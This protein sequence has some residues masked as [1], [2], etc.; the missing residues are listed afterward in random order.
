VTRCD[1]AIRQ[2]R[3]EAGIDENLSCRRSSKTT[4]SSFGLQITW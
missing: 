1:A 2:R 3:R 4:R